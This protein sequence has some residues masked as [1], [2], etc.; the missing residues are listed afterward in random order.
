MITMITTVLTMMTMLMKTI[1]P[2]LMNPSFPAPLQ[3]CLPP[4]LHPTCPASHLSCIPPVLHP[5]YPESLLSCIT[6][7]LHHSCSAFFLSCILPVLNPPFL[8]SLIP[9]FL[10][11]HIFWNTQ[12]SG[13]NL[14]WH[15]SPPPKMWLSGVKLKWAL[16]RWRTWDNVIILA[17]NMVRCIV[18]R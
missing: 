3:S 11:V 14:C 12:L 18:Q 1:I 6:P 5:T 15:E 9:A 7:V 10:C 13:T 8:H 16:P 4:V 2:H 17:E